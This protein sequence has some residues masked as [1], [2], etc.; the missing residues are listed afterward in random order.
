[1]EE[2][3][4]EDKRLFGLFILSAALNL[5]LVFALWYYYGI[6]DYMFDY[7]FDGEIGTGVVLVLRFRW[8]PWIMFSL[9]ILGLV[10]IFFSKINRLILLRGVIAILVTDIIVLAITLLIFAQELAMPMYEL[11]TA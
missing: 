6:M 10:L 3:T 9:S 5:L 1:M 7:L 4:K 11:G 2:I 8:W